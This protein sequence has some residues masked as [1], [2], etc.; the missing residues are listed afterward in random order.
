MHD[1]EGNQIKA[2]VYAFSGLFIPT[3]DRL[4]REIAE[5]NKHRIMQVMEFDNEA[6]RANKRKLKED[7]KH[8]MTMHAQKAKFPSVNAFLEDFY[9]LH[10]L[11]KQGGS[12]SN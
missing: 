1:E 4:K 2:N 9:Y 12:L 7:Y 3:K 5:F 10:G 11:S 8:C 6:I